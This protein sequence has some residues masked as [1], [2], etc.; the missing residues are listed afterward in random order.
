VARI[1]GT[2]SL[3]ENPEDVGRLAVAFIK[4]CQ[5]NGLV[6]TAKPRRQVL[7]TFANFPTTEYLQPRDI[8]FICFNVYLHQWQSFENYLARLQMQAE[9][10]PLLLGEIGIDSLREGEARQCELLAWQIESAFRGGLAGAIVFTFTDDWWHNG[11]RID[12]WRYRRGRDKV[13]STLFAADY[14]F[15]APKPADDIVEARGGRVVRIPLAQ[16]YSTTAILARIRS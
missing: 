2:R 4:G 11:R 15:G 10:K 5:E 8:D 6:A 1:W 7:I 16:G 3:G 14:I 12:D 13:M 9:G